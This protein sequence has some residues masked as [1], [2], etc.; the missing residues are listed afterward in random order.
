MEKTSVYK[1]IAAVSAALSKNGIS[2]ERKNAIQGYAFRGIDDVLNA[3][4]PLLA[5]HK[6]VI[7]PRVVSR[8]VSER[9]GKNG[10]ALFYVAVSME[11]EFVSAEDGSSCIVRTVGEAMDSGDKAT[12]KAMSAAYK[13]AAF[14]TFCIPTE[15][16]NDADATTHEVVPKAPVPVDRVGATK[17]LNPREIEMVKA[18]D[19]SDA[20]KVTDLS[21]EV[22]FLKEPAHI[23]NADMAV[24]NREKL[25]VIYDVKNGKNIVTDAIYQA[26]AKAK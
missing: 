13:Y 23:E 9:S 10:N 24:K 22:F 8:E 16:D 4:A 1:A 3:L 7:L 11:F 25:A 15:G 5:E 19:G 20:A 2:K 21:G 14:Q 18:K 26:V 12:N 17:T 6:L